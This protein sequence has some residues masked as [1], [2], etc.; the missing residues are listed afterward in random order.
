MLRDYLLERKAV[1]N[2][3][4]NTGGYWTLE[5]E[6]TR[7]MGLNPRVFLVEKFLAPGENITTVT[8]QGSR[9]IRSLLRNEVIDVPED[10]DT[11]PVDRYTWARYRTYKVERKFQTY[12]ALESALSSTLAILNS[13]TGNSIPLKATP[14]PRLVAINLSSTDKTPT[15]DSLKA[16]KG[17]TISLQIVGGPR[18]VNVLSDKDTLITSN[19][20]SL[21]LK[22]SVVMVKL[23]GDSHTYIGLLDEE[24]NTTYKVTVE[25][26]PTDEK[27]TAEVI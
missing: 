8:T 22:T 14:T 3:D 23:L 12:E 1:F 20:S 27:L 19:L 7:A 21:A 11:T 15:S 24:T 9:Y 2:S 13:N 18:S 4:P 17:D 6:V 26:L 16:Y 25:M 10:T 5:L